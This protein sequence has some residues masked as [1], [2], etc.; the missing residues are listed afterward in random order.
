MVSS[1]A[2]TVDDYLAELP[3]AR[4]AALSRLRDLCRTELPG[5]TEFMSYGMPTYERDGAGVAIASQKQYISVYVLRDDL[6][7]AFADRL[8][9]HDMGKSCL[10][11]RNPDTIDYDLIRDLLAAT[12][13]TPGSIC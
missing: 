8:A 5:F 1:A 9:G 11:F 2:A 7:A 3:D 6:R 13:A 12:A 4:R 10:R